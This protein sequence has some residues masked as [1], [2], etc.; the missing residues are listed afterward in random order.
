MQSKYSN[1]SQTVY[2]CLCGATHTC[3]TYYREAKHV[4]RFCID[5]SDCA[6]HFALA[7]TSDVIARMSFN[8]FKQLEFIKCPEQ[9][10]IKDCLLQ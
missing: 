5:H 8:Q 6:E 10:S 1:N 3:A 7:K 9:I 2:G 4:A